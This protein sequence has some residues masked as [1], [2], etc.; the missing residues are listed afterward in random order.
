MTQHGKRYRELGARYD[1][2]ALYGV[3][4]VVDLIKA[5]GWAKFD[6]TV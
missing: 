4:E 3:S 2:E 1:R 5:M 6:G